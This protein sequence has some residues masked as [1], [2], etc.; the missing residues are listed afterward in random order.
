MF[1]LGSEAE[2]VIRLIAE[3]TEQEMLFVCCLSAYLAGLA[4]EASPALL[5]ELLNLV[6]IN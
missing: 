3:P 2:R 1:N 4:V 6:A 5:V